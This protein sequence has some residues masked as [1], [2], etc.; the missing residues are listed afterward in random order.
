MYSI[1]IPAGYVLDLIF[2]DPQWKW[3]PVRII[4]RAIQ[5]LEKILNRENGNKILAGCVL[6]IL[7]VSAT[8]LCVWA[9][10]EL[11]RAI[12]PILYYII[13]A[14]S[15]YFVLSVK[16]L[17]VEARRV[18][19]ALTA[20]NIEEARR[21][22]SMI[23]G[24]DTHKLDEKET[25]RAAVETVAESIMDGIIA[26]LFYAF[27]GGPVLVWGYKAINTLDSMV[28]YKSERY[29]NFGKASAKLD[30]IVN[31]IPSKITAFL[32]TLASMF[33]KKNW[34]D[35]LKLTLKYLSK[36]PFYNS[37]VAE[38][39]MAG[40]LGI[41]LGGTNFYS[42]APVEKSLLGRPRKPLELSDITDSARI[43]YMVSM[44]GI[45]TGGAIWIWAI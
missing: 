4:G 16:S 3:H 32:I 2:G 19:K 42:G 7:V 44:F 45:L 26:P 38:A 13:S 21:I 24:R 41:Q 5:I 37:E 31:F 27:L 22:L 39:A 25:I 34:L 36:G 6:V 29:I 30:A 10:L 28:G 40:A 43:A 9:I 15:I 23:V 8:L 11:A 35:S 18:Y 14:I 17:G 1:I 12:H 33:F 20:G